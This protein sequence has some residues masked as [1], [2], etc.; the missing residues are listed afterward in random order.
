MKLHLLSLFAYGDWVNERLLETAAALSGA[1]F[2]RKLGPGFE[3][4]R[5]TFA[6]LLGGE[7]LWFARWQGESPKTILSADEVPDVP[8]LRA[9]WQRLSERRRANLASLREAD[10]NLIVHWINMRG[11]DFALLRWQVMLHSAN[12]STHHRSEIASMLTQLGHEPP[13]T[14]LIEYYLGLAGQ[15]WKP[16][17]LSPR[18]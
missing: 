10:L 8:A 14:D 2:D 17:N 13:S 1:Q 18:S 6:H 7:E 15:A 16:S 5:R 3:S 11:Q 12:H 9:R 4:V